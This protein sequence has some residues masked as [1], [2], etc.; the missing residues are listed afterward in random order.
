MLICLNKTYTIKATVAGSIVASSMSS[1]AL[2]E[3]AKVVVDEGSLVVD[4]EGVTPDP[5]STGK[6]RLTI[7]KERNFYYL[8]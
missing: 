8:N 2:V 5:N 1:G 3:L 7:F 6:F 4:V